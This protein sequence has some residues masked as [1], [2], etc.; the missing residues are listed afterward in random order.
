MN[1][2]TSHLQGFQEN[3]ENF[4]NN[5][6]N[7]L[8]KHCGLCHHCHMYSDVIV[9]SWME[10]TSNE[11]ESIQ[12]SLQ[13]VMRVMKS[14]LDGQTAQVQVVILLFSTKHFLVL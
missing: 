13:C 4:N 1:S 14:V 5:F 7:G 6:N 10:T 12:S 11:V 9:V 8:G 3:S 2:A